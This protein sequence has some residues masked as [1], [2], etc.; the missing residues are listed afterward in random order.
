M[1][2]SK[3]LLFSCNGQGLYLKRGLKEGKGLDKDIQ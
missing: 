2:L 3:D 1:E